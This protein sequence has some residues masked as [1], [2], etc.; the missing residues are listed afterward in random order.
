MKI[1]FKR[2]M[3]IYFKSEFVDF[4]YFTNLVNWKKNDV[5]LLT[6]YKYSTFKFKACTV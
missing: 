6:N 5:L 4:Y 2:F 1:I 3:Y